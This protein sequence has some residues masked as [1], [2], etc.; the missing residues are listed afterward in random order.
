MELFP[1]FHLLSISCKLGPSVV[2]RVKWVQLFSIIPSF[3]LIIIRGYHRPGLDTF[4]QEV[5]I[6]TPQWSSEGK[7]EK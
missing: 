7:V 6:E 5:I 2:L 1:N 4:N 3:I